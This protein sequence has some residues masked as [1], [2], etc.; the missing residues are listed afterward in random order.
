MNNQELQ[1]ITIVSSQAILMSICLQSMVEEL[2]R[3]K[4]KVPLR[5]VS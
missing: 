3:L 2:L 1:W 5:K 4:N